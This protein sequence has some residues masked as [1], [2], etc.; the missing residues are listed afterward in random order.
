M[1]DNNF[2]KK[3]LCKPVSLKNYL[4][5][6]KIKKVIIDDYANLALTTRG[7]IMIWG[8]QEEPDE[9][10]KNNKIVNDIEEFRKSAMSDWNLQ[11]I[12][13]R[14]NIVSFYIHENEEAEFDFLIEGRRKYIDRS[15]YT[16]SGRA[17]KLFSG[18]NNDTSLDKY[19]SDAKYLRFYLKRERPEE[20]IISA[21][22][23]D[24]DNWPGG[25]DDD[26]RFKNFDYFIFTNDDSDIKDMSFDARTK[27]ILYENGKLYGYGDNSKNQIS[28]LDRSFIR[29]DYDSYDY[30]KYEERWAEFAD[31]EGDD[32][33][34][35][36]E[37]QDYDPRYIIYVYPEH[38]HKDYTFQKVKT[39][40][41]KITLG[42]TTDNKL[43]FWGNNEN[44]LFNLNINEDTIKNPVV[45]A[46]EVLDFYRD[47][48]DSDSKIKMIITLKNKRM[49]VIGN[50][51]KCE[52]GVD[53]DGR[54]ITELTQVELPVTL[55]QV[56][57]YGGRTLGISDTGY[58]WGWG[59][60]TSGIITNQA[61]LE[62]VKENEEELRNEPVDFS[63]LDVLKQKSQ[64]IGIL[65]VDITEQLLKRFYK[66]KFPNY[67]N[68][69]E[70]FPILKQL[71]IPQNKLQVLYNEYKSLH[72]LSNENYEFSKTIIS[73]VT[74]IQDNDYIKSGELL[75]FY[76]YISDKKD[77]LLTPENKH[78]LMNILLRKST[79]ANTRFPEN[80][81]I[82]ITSIQNRENSSVFI[83]PARSTYS[84]NRYIQ[85]LQTFPIDK[86]KINLNN[87]YILE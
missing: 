37:Y 65:P 49:L 21:W 48:S 10:A 28:E 54:T 64:A 45:I 83:L 61:E 51:S 18:D 71:E 24:H 85:A 31:D 17:I 43:L 50:N 13:N 22:I 82:E 66:N 86:F 9:I 59:D 81:E 27:L 6:E 87:V 7:K 3:I 25:D 40:Y 78:D 39:Y 38:V 35:I 41:D 68:F 67:N 30:D 5:G 70:S 53:N 72:R 23:E 60:N 55:T 77:K 19:Y 63:S 73:N 26:M 79:N 36:D 12:S 80:I 74:K 2:N 56:Y 52:L 4:L 14:K 15:Y 33:D 29:S 16:E 69:L 76:N 62:Y 42:L 44:N 58:V 1:S 32:I 47:L 11:F 46:E 20:L 8:Q 34:D 57:S 84:L 75:D